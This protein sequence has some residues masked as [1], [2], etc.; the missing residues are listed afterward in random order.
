[1]LQRIGRHDAKSGFGAGLLS[2]MPPS[3]R[4]TLRSTSLLCKFRG[5]IAADGVFTGSKH[6]D[7]TQLLHCLSL[8]QPHC[9]YHC[10][11]VGNILDRGR[12][13]VGM[14]GL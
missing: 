1:M 2:S 12:E 13:I 14:G 9:Q 4:R 10:A 11:S 5:N 3:P 6:L 8:L 7:P